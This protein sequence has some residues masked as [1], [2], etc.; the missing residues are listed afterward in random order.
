MG[1]NYVAKE[2]INVPSVHPDDKIEITCATPEATIYYTLDGSTPSASKIKYTEPFS[3]NESCTIKAIAVKAGMNDSEIRT[4]SV[5]YFDNQEEEIEMIKKSY[6][7]NYVSD[8]VSDNEINIEFSNSNIGNE[9]TNDLASKTMICANVEF[10]DETFGKFSVQLDATM[11]GIYFAGNTLV[12]ESNCQFL[13]CPS[14]SGIRGAGDYGSVILNMFKT[15]TNCV[16]NIFYVEKN[17][18]TQTDHVS[19]TEA[20]FNSDRYTT[21][22]EG[23]Q[24]R[25][26]SFAGLPDW[27]NGKAG[28]GSD[29]IGQVSG[30]VKFLDGTQKPLFMCQKNEQ[31]GL[32][33]Y[34]LGFGTGMDDETALAFYV[35]PSYMGVENLVLE[36]MNPTGNNDYEV[37]LES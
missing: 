22:I 18:F 3:V 33:I 12:Y 30:Y 1:F 10:T 29:I 31:S 20:Y 13:I 7:F 37:Y 4:L 34:M 21:G 25:W 26:K 8:G 19:D 27:L 15:A 6:S 14:Y 24:M 32:V 9:I 2:G 35:S 16:F 5:E 23:T 36:Y 11:G 17:V 28:T